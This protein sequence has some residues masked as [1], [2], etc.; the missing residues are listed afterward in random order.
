MSTLF[1]KSSKTRKARKAKKAK[2]EIE[3]K[4]KPFLCLVPRLQK[5]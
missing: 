4:K 2:K 5:V 3:K 1:V